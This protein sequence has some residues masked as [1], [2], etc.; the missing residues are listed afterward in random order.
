[1]FI[2][3]TVKVNGSTEYNRGFDLVAE[4][5]TAFAEKA[6][7]MTVPLTA[8]GENL[9]LT[10]AST[11]AS[12]GD[13]GWPALSTP[14]GPWKHR[15]APGV[16]ML[17]GLQRTGPKGKRPQTYGISGAT[18][19][20]L[21]DT[22]AALHVTAKRMLYSP[23]SEIAGY[24]QDGTSK[25]PARPPVILSPATLHSWDREFTTWISELASQID[26]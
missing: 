2:Q 3:T 20:S 11:L 6:G 21:L 1:M 7:D 18:V 25:M 13:G 24:L 22:G 19:R 23:D 12:Q 5:L 16:P 9:M 10:V 14:Y 15:H 26:A 17:V 8:I 4:K